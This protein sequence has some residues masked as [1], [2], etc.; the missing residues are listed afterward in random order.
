MAT[1]HETMATMIRENELLKQTVPSVEEAIWGVQRAAI[2][3]ESALDSKTRVLIGYAIAASKQDE[4]CL[5]MLAPDLAK[6]G[7]TMQEVA[8]A[9][10]VVIL[11]NGGPGHVW[12]AHGLAVFEEFAKA[13]V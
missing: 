3:R 2:E 4:G 1:A 9:M 5:A 12:A 13:A 7:A 6:K 11:M 8:D 10:G